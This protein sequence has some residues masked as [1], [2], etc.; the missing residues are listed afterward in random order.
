[1]DLLPEGLL[2]SDEER[3]GPEVI[4]PEVPES[5]AP[6][7]VI[8]PEASEP[9]PEPP[10]PDLRPKPRLDLDFVAAEIAA[11]RTPM[12]PQCGV[13]LTK[14]PKPGALLPRGFERPDPEDHRC[15]PARL[16]RL[17]RAQAFVTRPG[18]TPLEARQRKAAVTET[19]TRPAPEEAELF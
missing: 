13:A 16:A 15:N 9:V 14:V 2:E 11:G 8:V 12:C 10:Q 1:M 17:A 3:L 18:E 5:E 19:Y 6:S 7:E 4:L